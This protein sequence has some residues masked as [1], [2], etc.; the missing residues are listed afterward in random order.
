MNLNDGKNDPSLVD[1]C[2]AKIGVRLRVR[3]LKGES[4]VCERLRE[5]GFCERAEIHKVSQNGALICVVCGSRVALSQRLGKEIMV[6]PLWPKAPGS[7][8]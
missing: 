8:Q 2:E 3:G 1:L 7:S 5:M 6:E 4:S